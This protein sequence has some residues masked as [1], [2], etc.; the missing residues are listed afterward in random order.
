M[1]IQNSIMRILNAVADIRSSISSSIM[2]I[3]HGSYG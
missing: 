2:G 3:I 1:D